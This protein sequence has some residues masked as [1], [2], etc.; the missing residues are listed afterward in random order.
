LGY[1]L[2]VWDFWKK[3]LSQLLGSILIII[4]NFINNLTIFGDFSQGA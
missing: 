2:F 1:K 4:E 3:E